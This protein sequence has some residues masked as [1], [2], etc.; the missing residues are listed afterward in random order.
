MGND[1][2]SLAHTK[3]RCQ[4]H[5]VFATK[6][7]RKAIYGV[8]RAET[9]KILR[10]ICSRYRVEI[11]EANACIDH[12]HMLILIERIKIH[13]NTQGEDDLRQVCPNEVQVWKQAFSGERILCGHGREEQ[14]RTGRR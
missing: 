5:V 6:Y 4:Y 13:G 1:T 7:R 14:G 9:G 11:I 10:T 3:W 2:E 8:Y 12:V